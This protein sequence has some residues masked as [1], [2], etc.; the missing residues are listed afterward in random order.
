MELSSQQPCGAVFRFEAG[1]EFIPTPL[2]AAVE[3]C[4]HSIKG[5]SF[6]PHD[7]YSGW[8]LEMARDWE[9]TQAGHIQPELIK[10][11]LVLISKSGINLCSLA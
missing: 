5:S 9:G 7:S 4:R 10:G 2:L 1:T 8:L 11:V 3:Q 6:S